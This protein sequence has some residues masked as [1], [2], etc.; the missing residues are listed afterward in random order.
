MKKIMTYL[1]GTAALPMLFTA[2]DLAL[3]KDYD[4]RPSVLDPRVE[5]T[6]WEYLH[7]RGDLFSIYIAAVERAQLETYFTQTRK[8]Y[9]FLALDNTA[10][11]AFM[12]D[13]EPR[14]GRIDD[15]DTETLRELLLYHLVEG[16]Y[17]SRGQLQ[18]TP[19]FVLT[20]L[21]GER[22]LMTLLV[23]K[24]PWQ[25]DAGKIVVNDAGSNGRSPMRLAVSGNIMPTN[26]VI[27]VFEEYCYYVK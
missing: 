19:M 7:A 22:G 23:R 9:T 26:G 25:A 24:N 27:H 1:F 18:V 21:S 12:A 8:K 10:M 2:C 5:M 15:Y 16:E 13:T 17:S 11:T 6:A 20:E 14:T 4:Y 3:Q